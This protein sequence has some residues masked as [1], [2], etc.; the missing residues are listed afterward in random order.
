MPKIRVEPLTPDRVA[1][2][3]NFFDHKAFVDNPGWASCYCRFYVANH[4]EKRWQDRTRDEN[5]AA[6]AARIQAGQHH[7]YLAYA[8]DQVVG[9]VHAAPRSVLPVLQTDPDLVIDDL[10][11]IGSLV[12]FNIAKDYRR[13]GVAR[14]LLDAA[15]EGF[16]QQSLRYAEGYP[17]KNT[18]SEAVNY[19]GP[20]ALYQAA[21]FTAFRDFD[22]FVIMRKALHI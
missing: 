10:D 5:R 7:G 13:Q 9:W 20:L 12:C 3:L 19:K 11:Q 6:I 2:Y 21:G 4:A 15:C 16:A 22:E 18:I 1:D 14:K 8:G 17:R